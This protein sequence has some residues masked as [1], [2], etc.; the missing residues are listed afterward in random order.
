MGKIL[1]V[2][3]VGLLELMDEHIIS[4]YAGGMQ[5]YKVRI[6]QAFD[7]Y[8][9][10]I[11]YMADPHGFRAQGKQV[12][13]VETSGVVPGKDC[14]VVFFMQP[15]ASQGGV[16]EKYLRK[17]PDGRSQQVIDDSGPGKIDVPIVHA[18]MKNI[19]EICR[20]HD[21]LLHGGIGVRRQVIGEAGTIIRVRAVTYCFYRVI[22]VRVIHKRDV[23]R[24][25]GL[26]KDYRTA[27]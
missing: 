1:P 7:P 13:A 23:E 21:G 17:D 2:K 5:A 18:I 24:K 4:L 8:Q 22:D 27:E 9:V 16:D 20:H 3:K 10:F 19:V 6:A 15:S 12:H 26:G 25:P 14:A 11:F